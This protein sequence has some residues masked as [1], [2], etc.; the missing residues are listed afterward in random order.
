MYLRHMRWSREI[1]ARSH[2]EWWS[3]GDMTGCIKFVT[4]TH[5]SWEGTSNEPPERKERGRVVRTLSRS[6]LPATVPL[7]SNNFLARVPSPHVEA[8][9]SAPVCSCSLSIRITIYG[10]R[11]TLYGQTVSGPA[12]FEKTGDASNAL[13][14]KYRTL[15]YLCS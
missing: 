9:H 3:S 10:I 15:Q 8:E 12:P 7:L 1:G 4:R 11:G 6:L 13:Q 5:L 14:Q 2:I